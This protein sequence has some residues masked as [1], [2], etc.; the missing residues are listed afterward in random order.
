M[1]HTDGTSILPSLPIPDMVTGLI[2]ALGALMGFRDRARNGGLYHVFASLTTA[3]AYPLSPEIGLYSRRWSRRL[4]RSS[5][6]S[7]WTPQC[8]P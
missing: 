2:G 6:G 5:N 3:A 7:L 4:I 1:E 8:S